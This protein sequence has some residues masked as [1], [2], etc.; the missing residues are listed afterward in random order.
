MRL[1]ISRRVHEQRTFPKNFLCNQP[2]LSFSMEQRLSLA[3]SSADS[4][5][6]WSTIYHHHT[7]KNKTKYKKR[8]CL[9]PIVSKK[10][11]VEDS[12]LSHVRLRTSKIQN[13]SFSLTFCWLRAIQDFEMSNA[14]FFAPGGHK[15]NSTASTRAILRSTKATFLRNVG[16]SRTGRR[17]NYRRRLLTCILGFDGK[18]EN[19]QQ[20]RTPWCRQSTTVTLIV[21]WILER[22][23][24]Q[25]RITQLILYES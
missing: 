21:A 10:S 15:V 23:H 11:A 24:S 18:P 13:W 7:T 22:S 25:N 4:L 8:T 6:T 17:S 3:L 9:R 1:E 19:R 2:V 14:P 5:R 16:P 12:K 20:P